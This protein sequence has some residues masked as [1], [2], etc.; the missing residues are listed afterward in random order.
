MG[1]SKEGQELRDS[2]LLSNNL[3]PQP[4]MLYGKTRKI[5]ATKNIVTKIFSCILRVSLLQ[6]KGI[7]IISSISAFS[8]FN[9]FAFLP[10]KY[11]IV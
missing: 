9:P 3:Q 7:F 11:S 8:H 2:D 5:S 1:F 6:T 10:K 4:L